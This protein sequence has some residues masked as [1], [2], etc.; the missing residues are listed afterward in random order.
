MGYSVRLTG[1]EWS[2][3][4]GCYHDLAHLEFQV[5]IEAIVLSMVRGM[6]RRDCRGVLTKNIIHRTKRGGLFVYS[7]CFSHFLLT[8]VREWDEAGRPCSSVIHAY[9]L[10]IRTANPT[11]DTHGNI[12]LF[13]SRLFFGHRQLIE[14]IKEHEFSSNNLE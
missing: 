1:D 5:T 8:T 9:H 11:Y 6:N 14:S 3:R 2:A 10:S 4:W 13:L 7:Y 12:F